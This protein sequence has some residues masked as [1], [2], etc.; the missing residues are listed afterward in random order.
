MATSCEVRPMPLQVNANTLDWRYFKDRF[1]DYL[2]FCE[3]EKASE[4]KKKALLLITLGRYGNDILDGLPTPKKTYTEC[5]QRLDDVLETK[6]QFF[7]VA[8]RF[9]QQD[10]NHVRVLLHLLADYVAWQRTVDLV[11]TASH[12]CVTFLSSASSMIDSGRSSFQKM[13]RPWP[14]ILP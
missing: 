3:L 4:E 1:S 8:K 14:L 9:S 10:R 13:I 7:C 2:V 12:C 5:V 6:P 11:P